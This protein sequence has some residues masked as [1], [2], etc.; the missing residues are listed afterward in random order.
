VTF[1]GKVPEGTAGFRW[2]YDLT[3]TSYTLTVKTAGTDAGPM[4]SIET[5]Q[6]ADMA[7]VRLPAPPTAGQQFLT[8]A[9]L[10]A[11]RIFP[12]GIAQI[13]LLLGLVLARPRDRRFAVQALA[14]A[15]GQMLTIASLALLGTSVTP[16]V[17]VPLMAVSVGIAW[18]SALRPTNL[19]TGWSAG[20]VLVLATPFGFS[21]HQG[22]TLLSAGGI[23]WIGF[24]S[25]IGLCQVATAM[26]IRFLVAPLADARGVRQ[27]LLARHV[28]TSG[29]L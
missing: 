22:L 23:E 25:G 12:H 28:V 4:R 11:S 26:L 7:I 21:L 1:E 5:G 15:A 24:I 14:L 20:L 8:A 27:S 18:L 19:H 2:Q 3:A 16:A 9:R 29:N 10:G 17:H 6:E 13:V